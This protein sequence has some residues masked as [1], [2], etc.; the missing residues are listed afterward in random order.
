MKKLIV[1]FVL[2]VVCIGS[3]CAADEFKDMKEA[4]ALNVEGAYIIDLKPFRKKIED[5]ITF[6]NMSEKNGIAFIIYYIDY[7]TGKWVKNT[8]RGFVKT[9]NDRDIV[10]LDKRYVT[11][12][13]KNNNR[14][15]Q[16]VKR[17]T[18][19]KKI[20]FIAI[21]PEPAGNYEFEIYP[22]SNDIYIEIT[23]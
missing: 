9:Y 22:K 3:V 14:Y 18:S 20:P 12:P 6:L 15:D 8:N 1:L 13:A 23:K 17:P 7:D 21:V 16:K 4:P 11:I 2:A 19:L 5:N 10:E